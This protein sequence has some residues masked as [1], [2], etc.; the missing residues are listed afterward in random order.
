M[1]KIEKEGRE[2]V[3]D[4]PSR[5]P[6]AKILLIEDDYRLR[7]EISAAL[8]EARYS[9]I[10]ARTLADA[11]AQLRSEPDLIL[12][13]LMLPDG[14]GLEL[15]RE[16]RANGLDTP[17]IAVTARDAIEQRVEGLDAGVDDYLVKPFSVVELLARIRSVTRRYLGHVAAGRVEIGR[18]WIDRASRTAGKD[19]AVLDLTPQE[20]DLLAFLVQHPGTTWSRDQLLRHAWGFSSSIGDTRTVDTH[21]RRLRV[22]IEDDPASPRLLCTVW[23]TGYRFSEDRG[24]G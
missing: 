21:V 12:L 5:T 19:M 15:C 3:A 10:T 7:T 9:T 1:S 6:N 20:Y 23:G 13:D 24:S 8:T 11:R 2:A 16:L 17:I 4:V 14:S 22:K 18:L